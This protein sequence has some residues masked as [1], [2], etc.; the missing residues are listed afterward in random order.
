MDL[1]GPLE[2]AVVIVFTKPELK[3]L[4]AIS[5]RGNIHPSTLCMIFIEAG[6]DAGEEIVKEVLDEGSQVPA[7][8]N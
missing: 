8:P 1:I 5:D 3:R 7:V 6:L 2:S 4:R